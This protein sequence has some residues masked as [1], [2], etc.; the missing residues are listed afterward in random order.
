MRHPTFTVVTKVYNEEALVG[1]AIRSAL[2][3]TET[4]S[5]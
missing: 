4:T 5:S 2:A 1:E 3:Q